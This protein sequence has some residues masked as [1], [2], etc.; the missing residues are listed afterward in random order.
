[1][2]RDKYIL[3][4][5]DSFTWGQGL[6]LPSW[7]ERKPE[8]LHQFLETHK[9][10]AYEIAMQWVEQEPHFDLEDA[11]I[12]EKLSFTGIVGH[13][14]DRK[15]IKKANNGGSITTNLVQ[16]NNKVFPY[17]INDDMEIG[18]ID[19]YDRFL[20]KD[21]IIVFQFSS[22]GRE[23]F[24]NLTEEEMNMVFETSKSF[25]DII[26]DRIKGLF[27][28]VDSKLMEIEK[29]YG[30]KYYYLDWLGDFYDFKPEKFITI[31]GHHYFNTMTATNYIKVPY[32]DKF[33]CDGHINEYGNM[34]IAKNI[35]KK[36]NE[37]NLDNS[38]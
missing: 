36:I 11:K 20:P 17:Y 4:L 30:F 35:L 9:G 34:I 14:L 25:K 29:K 38:K 8:V 12:K 6:Y 7:V 24:D 31:N 19:L 13:R 15:V 18:Y 27:D 16:L 2:A 37:D 21:C 32:K 23:D 26:Y 5:G 22:V 10:S 28:K 1:M 3:F 33:V